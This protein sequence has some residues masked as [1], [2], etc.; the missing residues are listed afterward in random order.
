MGNEL[1]KP[2][3]FGEMGEAMRAL[4]NDR[5]RA[6]VR[7][8]CSLSG[9]GAPTEAYRR[10]GFGATSTKKIQAI[11]AHHL[12]RDDRIIAAIAEESRKILRGAHPEAINTVIE[13]MRDS[14]HKDRLKAANVILDRTDPQV[15]L[16]NISVTHKTIDPDQEALEELA[17]VRSIGASREKLIELFGE[18]DLARLEKL[19]A[20]Q[21]SRRAEE[22]KMIE[23]KVVDNG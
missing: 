5:W 15:T 22:A 11:D 3:S 7:H 1:T 19:E 10:A 6:F 8:Y 20:R 4:P 9:Y 13:V 2:E 18:N 12:M 16:Q 21:N 23:A 14:Q 17:A